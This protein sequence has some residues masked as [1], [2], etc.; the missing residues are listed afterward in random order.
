MVVVALGAS[1][2]AEFNRLISRGCQAL[3]LLEWSACKDSN[4]DHALIW[5]E[6]G[7]SPL[8]CHY[9]TRRLKWKPRWDLNPQFQD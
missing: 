6:R 4:L 2:V 8:C 3:G 1:T 7:I 5:R 9:T